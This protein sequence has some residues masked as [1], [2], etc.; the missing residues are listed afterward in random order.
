[1]AGIGRQLGIMR[2]LLLEFL[3]VL[4]CGIGL[5]ATATAAA[6]FPEDCKLVRQ[7]TLPFAL[8]RGHIVVEVAVNGHPLHFM[9]D[10]GGAFSAISSEAA[11]AIG[12]H[13]TPLGMAFKIQDAGGAE[14]S[15]IARIEYISFAKFRSE[16]LTLM[17]A[18]LPPGEDGVLAPELL[19][20]FDIE[21]DFAT[22]TMNLF[23]RPRC[24][25]H[26][27]Y[28]TDDFVKLPM[29]VTEQ[30]HIQIPVAVNG[31]TIKA[32][33]DTGS[34]YTLIGDNA[35]EAIIGDGKETGKSVSLSGGSGGKLG[36]VGIAPD[37]LIIGKFKW[38]SP[39]LISTPNKTGWHQDGSEMLLGL[40]ILHDLHLFIDYKGGQ[41]FVSRR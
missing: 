32:T 22:Q 28:W 29:R 18:S 2:R 8:D 14:V 31:Q 4:V 21:L 33:I 1:M 5:G 12:L 36:G 7:A 25:E 23:K 26:V 10:T 39:T 11:Q 3:L 6:E 19:R 16:N 9:V 40:D 41:F 38:V 27:V 37:S 17:I 24:D 15:R 34:P 30:G 13:P 20:N 35:A